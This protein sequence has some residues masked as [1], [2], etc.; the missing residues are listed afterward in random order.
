[1]TLEIIIGAVVIAVVAVY[2]TFEWL[3]HVRRRC[4]DCAKAIS[5]SAAVCP[6]CGHRFSAADPA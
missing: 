1:V 5:R 6:Y 2:L 3:H 4:P